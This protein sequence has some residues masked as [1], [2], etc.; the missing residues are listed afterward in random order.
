MNKPSIGFFNKELASQY[1]EKNS[2]LKPISECLH[3]LVGSVLKDL[4]EESRVL[5][6]GAGTGAEILTL[7]HLFP[8]WTFVAVDPAPAML[9]VCKERI[10]KTGILERCKFVEGYIHDVKE[11]EFDAVV[12]LLAGHF[13]KQEDRLGFYQGMVERLRHKGYLVNAEISYNLHSPEFPSMLKN[14][15]EIQKLLGAT[16]ESIAMLP[17]ALKEMLT[18]LPPQ[19]IENYIRSS[20]V[21][22]PVRFFQAFMICG[23]YGMKNS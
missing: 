5:S 13:V 10:Q 20:G 19:D 8:K 12:S 4:P 7:A 21:D 23:W 17:R 18:V 11:S 2:R 22:T 16:P 1:D 15:E 14:W 9:E 6:V 3:F